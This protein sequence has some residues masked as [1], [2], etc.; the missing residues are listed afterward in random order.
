[1]PVAVVFLLRAV[2]LV[3]LW[4]FV[5]A[6]VL[7][8]RHDVFG[9]RPGKAA[10][11]APLITPPTPR[12]A[13]PTP[14]PPAPAPKAS[15]RRNKK[16][17]ASQVAVVEGPA[18]GATVALSSLPVTIGRANSSSIVLSDDV[19]SNNHARITPRGE[20]WLLEDLGSTNGTFVAGT[21][22]TVPVVVPVGTRITIGR[23][24]LEIR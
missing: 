8:V 18:T 22:V 11:V 10:K 5:V 23:N 24:T 7:A 19:V 20:D 12:P 21:K 1:V 4:G 16:A 14:S 3:L 9:T 2:V 15:R 6:A 13:A 17:P